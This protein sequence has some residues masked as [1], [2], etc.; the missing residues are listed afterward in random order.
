ME[1]EKVAKQFVFGDANLKE[2]GSKPSRSV[3]DVLN[4]M[5]A[6]VNVDLLQSLGLP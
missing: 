1:R 5:L 4:L 6:V 3:R 2:G